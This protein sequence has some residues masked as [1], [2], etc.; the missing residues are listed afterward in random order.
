MFKAYLSIF[1]LKHKLLVQVLQHN[2][3]TIHCTLYSVVQSDIDNI[4]WVR[5]AILLFWH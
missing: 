5:P 4:M 1:V 2:M 3:S